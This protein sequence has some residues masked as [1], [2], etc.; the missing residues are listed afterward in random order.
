ML[1]HR[2]ILGLNDPKVQTDH[3]NGNGLDNCRKNLRVANH[4]QNG[5]N[6]PAHRNSTTGYRGVTIDRSDGLYTAAVGSSPRQYLGHYNTP[7][8]AARAYDIAARER[9]GE[10]AHINLPDATFIPTKRAHKRKSNGRYASS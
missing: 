9:Y 4:K 8:E 6:G 7:E 10:F 1:M 3:K 2:M 5:A